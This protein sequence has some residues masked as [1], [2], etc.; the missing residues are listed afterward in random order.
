LAE[1]EGERDAVHSFPFSLSFEP[2]K[3]AKIKKIKKIQSENK[4]KG[5]NKLKLKKKL[6]LAA[7]YS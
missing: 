5:I 4:E 6:E 7:R 2:S 1:A 3:P